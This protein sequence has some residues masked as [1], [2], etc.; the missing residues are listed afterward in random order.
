MVGPDGVTEDAEKA[1]A[2]I[3]IK[4]YPDLHFERL[5]YKKG[6]PMVMLRY[7][8]DENLKILDGRYFEYAA[9]G[10]V[11]LSGNY[12][13]NA[14]HGYWRVYDD[15]GKVIQKVRYANDSIVE[16]IDLARIDSPGITTI[17]REA[18]FPGGDKAWRKYL[19]RKLEED[20]PVMK[21][22]RGGTVQVSFVVGK[23]GSIEDLFLIKSVEY[24]L[25]EASLRIIS[26]SPKWIPAF[27]NGKNIRVYK[28][29][30]LSFFKE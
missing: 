23:D 17:E 22:F 19:I 14:K 10:V 13:N 26:Q 12:L 2:F 6:A 15:T 29:Q 24:V 3:V 1:T 7:Y 21:S 28:K 25:D 4:Q 20:N 16:T 9:S 18:L 8:K 11:H 5:D 27:H 30:P